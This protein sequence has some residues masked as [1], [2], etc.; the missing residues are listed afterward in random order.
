[1]QMKFSNFL[2]S[3]LQICTILLRRNSAK[4]YGMDKRL[5][6]V[7]CKTS[8]ILLIDIISFKL[9][10]INFLYFFETPGSGISLT[11]VLKD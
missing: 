8:Y 1:M 2:D 7:E 4:T 11:D 10:L 3:L 5:C 6:C 9:C